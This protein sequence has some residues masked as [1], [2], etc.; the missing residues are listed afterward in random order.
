MSGLIAFQNIYLFYFKFLLNI[1]LIYN[2]NNEKL[3]KLIFLWF[4][5]NN[6][7]LILFTIYNFKYN[8]YHINFN[9]Y[10]ITYN[11]YIFYS[12]NRLV[13]LIYF[14]KIF[15]HFFKIIY[16]IFFLR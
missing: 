14:Y 6:Y 2:N 13:K 12:W 5:C 15:L 16:F 10:A 1:I 9:T 11:K 8:L 7:L 3:N 4:L